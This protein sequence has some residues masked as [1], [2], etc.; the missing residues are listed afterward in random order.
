MAVVVIV[1]KLLLD[2][3]LGFPFVLAFILEGAVLGIVFFA[4]VNIFFG[5]VFSDV[6]L[7][8]SYFLLLTSSNSCLVLFNLDLVVVYFFFN[9][10]VCLKFFYMKS[11]RVLSVT[12]V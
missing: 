5:A 11:D 9:F 4:K 10:S 2:L 3:I 1:V 6:E 8:D 7:T 12:G